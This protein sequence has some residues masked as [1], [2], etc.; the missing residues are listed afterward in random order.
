VSA[1]ALPPA[2]PRFADGTAWIDNRIV[3]VA[4]ATLP[5]L[6]WG[7]LRSDACQETISARDGVLFRLND[8]LDRFERSLGRLRMTSPLTRE[9]IRQAIH[10]LIATAGFRDAYV[11]IIMTRGR[12]PIGSRDIR[13]CANRF[14]AFCIPYVWIAT[15]E[16]QARGLHLHVSRR[17]RVPP[18]S[19]DPMVKHYHWLDF[20]MGLMEA[21]DSG[22]ETV[23]LSDADGNITEGPGFNIFIRQGETLLTPRHGMLDG[24][25]RRTIL[26]IC[27][28]LGIPVEQTEVSLE[29]LLA[30]D[31]VFITSTAGGVM[32]VTRVDDTAIRNGP[33]PVAARLRD[34]YWTR[35]KDGWLGED[36]DYGS[37][38]H[39]RQ[40]PSA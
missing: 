25:T 4:E 38:P 31:E 37:N 12:P 20:E 24:M 9:E 15:P 29:A 21:H 35:R 1:Q 13:L 14:Q 19:V 34:A 2:E 5:L 23:V 30:A 26:E 16:V 40:E 36:V 3:P 18:A 32:P 11:Q 10:R 39:A 8:H 33:G 27:G 6:D 28:D 22:A 17:L 7:F